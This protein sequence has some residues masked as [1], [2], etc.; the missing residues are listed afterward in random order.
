MVVKSKM[1]DLYQ[2]E[3]HGEISE[4][5]EYHG[6]HHMKIKIKDQDNKIIDETIFS[7]FIS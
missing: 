3:Y 2:G 1:M 4:S 6:L 7:I 5:T